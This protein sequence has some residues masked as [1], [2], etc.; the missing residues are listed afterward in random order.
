MFNLTIVCTSDVLTR[1]FSGLI[2]G[3]CQ[4]K[5]NGLNEISLQPQELL[6]KPKILPS[7]KCDLSWVE[8]SHS[9]GT[10]KKSYKELFG[11]LKLIRIFFEREI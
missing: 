11:N 7:E 6:L 1:F 3:C 5:S 9:R 4:V 2:A 10:Q 8:R